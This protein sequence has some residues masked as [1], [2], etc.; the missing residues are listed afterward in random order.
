MEILYDDREKI[1][2]LILAGYE[3]GIIEKP[4][5]KNIHWKLEINND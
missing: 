1:A 2:T 5:G 4:E 3:E